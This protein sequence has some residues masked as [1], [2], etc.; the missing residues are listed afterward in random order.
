VLLKR[1]GILHADFK[2]DNVLL[3]TAPN[4]PREIVYDASVLGT[5]GPFS[6]SSH[7]SDALVVLADY[8]RSVPVP[9]KLLQ[10]R[11]S[12]I[13]QRSPLL[14]GIRH[15]YARMLEFLRSRLRPTRA[16]FLNK[17]GKVGKV[18][19]EYEAVLQQAEAAL[20]QA[21]SM[22]VPF[23]EQAR[24]FLLALLRGGAEHPS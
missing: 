16:S 3:V 20:E 1:L 23:L 14:D 12:E 11:P 13:P 10:R 5:S 9:P 7:N 22:D 4:M 21:F 15:D 8:G 2:A 18:D 17:N 6:V 24:Q 19:L